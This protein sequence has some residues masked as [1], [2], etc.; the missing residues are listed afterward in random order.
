[1]KKIFLF[2]IL[3]VIFS[4]KSLFLK[5]QV[6]DLNLV[7]R[8]SFLNNLYISSNGKALL[9]A[10]LLYNAE[11][12]GALYRDYE[13]DNLIFEIENIMIFSN[14]ANGWTSAKL[15]AYGKLSFKKD[16]SM[17]FVSVIEP[18]SIWRTQSGSIKYFNDYYTGDDGLK[19]VDDRLKRIMEFVLVLKSEF[20]NA[21]FYNIYHKNSNGKTFYQSSREFLFPETVNLQ[22]LKE[23]TNKFFDKNDSF[24]FGYIWSHAYSKKI[25]PEELRELRNSGT[26]WRDFEEAAG[27]F[28]FYYNL[29]YYNEYLDGSEFTVVKDISL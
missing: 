5:G 8:V 16:G 20:K 21:P 28:L 22:I 11:F 10:H 3:F 15:S 7:D 27:I 29:N 24:S 17:F 13:S 9:K 23:K 2:L 6:D 4:C 18:L 19:K 1:M 26:I 25:L 14:W 12:E